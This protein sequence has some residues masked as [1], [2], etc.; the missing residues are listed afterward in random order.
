[1]TGTA[2]TAPG[3][4]A[5]WARSQQSHVPDQGCLQALAVLGSQAECSKQHSVPTRAGIVPP[6]RGGDST[7]AEE[8]QPSP[9]GRLPSAEEHRNPFFGECRVSSPL[10]FSGGVSC[11]FSSSWYASL[12]RRAEPL[13]KAADIGHNKP[14]SSREARKVML[15]KGCKSKLASNYH[16][17]RSSNKR[18]WDREPP[19]NELWELQEVKMNAGAALQIQMSQSEK[20]NPRWKTSF[21]ILLL[22]MNCIY[23]KK[24]FSHIWVVWL[25]FSDLLP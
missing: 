20:E 21:S 3:S 23:F 6:G 15:A 17:P 14:S 7:K 12:G 25:K 4:S 10:L 1:M 22:G 9:A 8:R 24:L 13:R 2:Q 18:P 11:L 19:K 16:W 5:G